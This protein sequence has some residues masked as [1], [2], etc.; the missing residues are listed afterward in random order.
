EIHGRALGPLLRVSLVDVGRHV[1]RPAQLESDGRYRAKL[2]P[3]AREPRV[4]LYASDE[5]W[6]ESKILELPP[7]GGVTEAPP[8]ALWTSP[9]DVAV[10]ADQIRFNWAPIPEGE[11][12]PARRRYSL[13]VRF[14]KDDGELGEVSFISMEPGRTTSLGELHELL[15]QRDA[16][17]VDVTLELRAYDPGIKDGPLWV[18][19]RRPW[20]LPPPPKAPDGGA[21]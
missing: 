10:D 11:G 18:A 7:E 6:V 17:S 13:L 19:G 4:F 5:S 12:Y 14:K 16:T 2:P 15:L 1:Q 3:F 9:I 21:R 20:K 8:Y